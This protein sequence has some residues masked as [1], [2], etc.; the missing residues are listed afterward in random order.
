[1][2]GATV[3]NA[4]IIGSDL[5]PRRPARGWPCGLRLPSPMRKPL[6][7]GGAAACQGIPYEKLGADGASSP[8][9]PPFLL[10][11]GIRP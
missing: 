5:V 4:S 8:E 2:G 9:A 7:S 3:A 1:M 6:F 10:R 11:T